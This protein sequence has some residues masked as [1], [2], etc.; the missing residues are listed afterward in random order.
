MSEKI[1]PLGNGLS[2]SP[3]TAADKPALVKYLNEREIFLR[4]LNI[5]FPYKES[6][7]D[8]WIAYQTREAAKNDGTATALA[9]RSPEGEMIGS[10]GL[11]GLVIGEHH[12]AELG[13]WLAKPFWGK[14]IMTG[15]AATMCKLG[16]GEFGL[17][18]ITSSVF[19]FNTGSQRVL[20][21]N[22]FV[23]EGSLKRHYEKEGRLLD[24]LVFAKFR[25]VGDDL[26]AKSRK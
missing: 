10:V 6:D 24:A 3:L 21:K 26:D 1:I 25:Q 18:K 5:P 15:A 11:D 19:S 9:I 22:A 4:T 13:Y 16:F 8:F 17:H 20:E 23:Q 7:A 14:G 12:R 2:L